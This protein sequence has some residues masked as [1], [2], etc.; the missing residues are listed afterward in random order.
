MS[1]AKHR[2]GEH[3]RSENLH[4]NENFDFLFSARKSTELFHKFACL[5]YGIPAF[6]YFKHVFNPLFTCSD[7]DNRPQPLVTRYRSLALTVMSDPIAAEKEPAPDAT[8]SGNAADDGKKGA[9]KREKLIR[10]RGKRGGAKN[11]KSKDAEIKSE[12]AKAK[13][14]AKGKVQAETKATAKK[15]APKSAVA[16]ESTEEKTAHSLKIASFHTLL[17]RI[18]QT[19]DPKE[20]LKL[21]KQLVE[22]HGGIDAYQKESLKGRDRLNGGETG[23]WLSEQLAEPWKLKQQKHGQ[24]KVRD[25]SAPLMIW[26]TC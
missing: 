14:K 26:P 24:R 8:L 7:L 5:R 20:K 17:K 9:S 23:K 15:D 22:E 3:A 25:R 13:V 19:K 21:E 4:E 2:D 10:P 6:Q 11:R 16:E 12:A 18:A 1:K